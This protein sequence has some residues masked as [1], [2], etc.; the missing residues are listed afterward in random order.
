MSKYNQKCNLINSASIIIIDFNSAVRTVKYI[1]DFRNF[2]HLKFPHFIIIDNSCNFNNLNV[3]LEGDFKKEATDLTGFLYWDRVNDVAVYDS[4]IN[5]GFAKGNN[6]GFH[7][8]KELYNDSI[9]LFSNN[10]IRFDATFDFR[11]LAKIILENDKI[12]AVGPRVVGLNGL[13][14]SPYIYQNIYTRWIIPDFLWPINKFFSKDETDIFSLTQ[15]GMVY[16][17]LGAFLVLS[18]EAFEKIGGFDENTFLYAE[19][20]ILSERLI[21]MDYETYYCHDVIVMHE[22]GYTTNQS[23]HSHE[24]LKQRFKSEMYYFETYKN[25]HKSIIILAKWSLTFFFF[26]KKIIKFIMNKI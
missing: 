15:S 7:I 12:A 21:K 8:A 14:Q 19:E 16:R 4:P 17:L 26:K 2:S 24:R 6:I 13:N 23:M 20:L 1:K 18:A 22:G 11:I 9:I 25:V 3:L 10:D 5:E